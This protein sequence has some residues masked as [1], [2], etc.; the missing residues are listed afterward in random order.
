MHFSMCQILTTHSY[1]TSI[2]IL[3][4]LKALL[5]VCM[6][7]TARNESLVANIAICHMQDF[8]QELHTFMHTPEWQCFI[9]S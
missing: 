1:I 6:K 8:H 3:Y 2:M 4:Y 9:V 5:P 7:C